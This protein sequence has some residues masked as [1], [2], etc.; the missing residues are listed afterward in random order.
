MRVVGWVHK[1]LLVLAAPVA[2]WTAFEMYLLTITGPQMLF[3][4]IVHAYPNILAMNYLSAPFFLILAIYNCVLLS[5]TL[6][7]SINI[8]PP[9]VPGIVLLF[10]DL[11]VL[12]LFTYEQ[13]AHSGY[14]VFICLLGLVILVGVTIIS[15]NG[16]KQIKAHLKGPE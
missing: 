16:G 4:S 8:M 10:Q 14:R 1:V 9:I 5:L 12:A 3:Y 13:W 15:I 6:T 7:M 2:F 11:H